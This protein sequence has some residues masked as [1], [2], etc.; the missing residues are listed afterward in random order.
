MKNYDIRELVE[1]YSDMIMWIAYQN[2]FNKS[3]SEDIVQEV[4]VKLMKNINNV[5]EE[6][7]KAWI[8]RVTIN[9]CKDYNKSAWYRKVIPIEEN[10]ADFYFDNE[11]LGIL[12][13]LSKLKPIYR[14]IV[15]L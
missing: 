1:T 6:Y 13:E 11:E 8:I 14:N 7:I 3:D 10:E 9:N 2:S 12:E 15:Y 5:E 4:F